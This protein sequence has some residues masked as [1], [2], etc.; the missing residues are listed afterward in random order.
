MKMVCR[1]KAETI[2]PVLLKFVDSGLCRG[3]SRNFG[4]GAR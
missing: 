2:P 1:I 4:K 3:G